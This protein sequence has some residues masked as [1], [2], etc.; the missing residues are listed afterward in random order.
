MT[1][2]HPS[3]ELKMKIKKIAAITLLGVA[4]GL[5][6]AQDAPMTDPASGKSCV[7][8]FSSE[9][10]DLGLVVMHY[11]NI[12]NSSFEIRISGAKT[13]RGTIKAGAPDKPSKGTVTCRA[14]DK[15][16]TADWKFETPNAN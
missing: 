2:P 3:Q 11:R 4:T 1:N 9:Q 7:S 16:E 5:A 12:C 14:D 15:C 8:F 13:R 10:A 6:Q